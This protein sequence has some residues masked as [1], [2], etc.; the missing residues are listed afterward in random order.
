MSK[1]DLFGYVK[2]IRIYS[3]IEL[4]VFCI[5]IVGLIFIYFPL[6]GMRICSEWDYSKANCVGFVFLLQ[7]Q[8]Y[9][10]QIVILVLSCISFFAS[11]SEG[12]LLIGSIVSLL[13]QIWVVYVLNK[14]LKLM[15]EEGANVSFA[16][17]YESADAPCKCI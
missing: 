7:V 16:P 15:K 13:L 1:Q 5:S 11:F 4:V 10:F 9:I 2:A 6:C 3:I 14:I 12:S 17:E 8:Y